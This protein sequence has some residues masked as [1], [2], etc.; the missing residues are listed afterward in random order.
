[1]APERYTK[2]PF[3]AAVAGLG[4]LSLAVGSLGVELGRLD[5][6]MVLLLMGIAAVAQ[7]LPVF[8]FRSSAISMAFAAT[9][10]AYVLYGPG[11]ALWV[12]L[13]SAAVSAFT[14]RRKPLEK[15]LFNT[16]NLTLSAYLAGLTYAALAGILPPQDIVGVI[17]AVTTSA[18]VYFAVNS[19]L[20]AQ[21][22]A[23]T[24]G[25]SVVGIWRENYA[26]MVVNYL[27]TAVNGASLAIGYQT[28]GLLGVLTFMLP[29]AIAW[30]SFKLYMA[31]SQEVRARNDELNA[32]NVELKLT[33]NRL[34]ESHLSIVS[35]LVGALEAKDRHTHGHSAATMFH[36]VAVARR[37]GLSER[38]I[39]E[40]QLGALFHDI[41]KI[42]I[43]ESLLRKPDK[44][45]P[46]EWTEIK[47]HPVIGANLLANVPALKN[48]QPIV[49]AHHERYD[50]T[51]YPN[52]LRGD[53]IPI[54]AQVISVADAYQ[55]M[56]SNRPYRPAMTRKQA[57]DELRLAAGTQFNPLVVETFFATLDE[58][59]SRGATEDPADEPIHGSIYQ[60]AAE[61]VQ[62]ASRIA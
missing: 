12:N 61:A 43:P 47:R 18:A 3:I 4:A 53:Q 27:A 40:V 34:G 32:A 50:G 33:N 10:A 45:T 48:L 38:E 17:L 1:M 13:A 56:T 42:G 16:G 54:S 30:Y 2:R 31:K 58:R 57:V 21:V 9:I 25:S 23:L 29:L 7:R 6:V 49:L 44:L 15:V 60:Q 62:A 19:A 14:P 24:T 20:T 52:G 36:A 59:R 55:A 5:V 8:L 26:W 51:G 37:L 46:S 28:V 11:L 39:A 22:I 35:A 41:G